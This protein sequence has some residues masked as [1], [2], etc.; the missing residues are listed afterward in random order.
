M[1]FVS[2]KF[3]QLVLFSL[4]ACW[5]TRRQAPAFTRH[6]G[7]HV[8]LW[9]NEDVNNDGFLIAYERVN[10]GKISLDG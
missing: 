4:R 1:T 9:T 7:L 8:L 5:V 10:H 3:G 2:N 6:P